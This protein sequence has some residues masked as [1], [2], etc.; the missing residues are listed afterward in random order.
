MQGGDPVAQ[1]C[2]DECLF[3]EELEETLGEQME[4][5]DMCDHKAQPPACRYLHRLRN[6]KAIVSS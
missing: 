5:S 4:F 1:G 3:A 2:R 6:P